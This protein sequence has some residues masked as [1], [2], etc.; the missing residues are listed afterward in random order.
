MYG[1]K[2]RITKILPTN[3]IREILT[4]N[5]QSLYCQALFLTQGP[6]SLKV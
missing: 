4:I 2:K 5:S 6:I 3:R 1:L